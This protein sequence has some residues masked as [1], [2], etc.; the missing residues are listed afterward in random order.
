MEDIS[1]RRFLRDASVGAVALGAA[2]TVGREAVGKLV[3]PSP[4]AATTAAMATGAGNRAT[5]NANDEV[6]AHVVGGPSGTI[7][8]YS[9]TNVVTLHNLG[10][11]S[12]L[13]GALRS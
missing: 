5:E 3:K 10:V 9:G 2:A 12:T 7:E 8:I 6:M 1:R 4:R 13:L 11:A